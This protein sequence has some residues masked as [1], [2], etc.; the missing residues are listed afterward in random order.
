MG[1]V[2]FK[3]KSLLNP[4]ELPGLYVHVP[5]CRRKCAYCSFYSV[6]DLSLIPACLKAIL[7]EARLYEGQ[8]GVFDTLYLGGGTPS[9]LTADQL[10]YLLA[11]LK[12]QLPLVPEAEITLEANPDDVSPERLACWQELGINRLSLGVQSFADQELTFLGRRH[13]ARQAWQALEMSRTAFANLNVDLIYALPGQTI[14]TWWA[15]LKQA[16]TFEP[17]HLSCYQLTLE[18]D[19]PLGKLKAARR[20]HSLSENQQRRFFLATSRFLRDQGYLHYEVSNFARGTTRQARHNRKYWRRTPYLGLGP[21]AHS[22]LGRRRWW[23]HPSVTLYCQSL[24]RGQP[25]VAGRET[26][27]DSQIRLETL[28]LGFRTQEGV[29][30][31][32]LQE[33]PSGDSLLSRLQ[34]AKLLR[35]ADSQ[36]V[37]T[38]QGMLMADGLA[39]LFGE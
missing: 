23:N 6:T 26:L 1:T 21:A 2:A 32:L 8:F 28:F 34:K 9:V 7:Q 29:K 33:H 15:H 22:F 19:T 18:E 25:P 38:P 36:V 10:Q 12:R 27:S 14:K 4:A 13:R 20:F 16:L 30:L 11:G 37:P 17:D 39:L 31:K 24:S 5:F 35:V 3:N